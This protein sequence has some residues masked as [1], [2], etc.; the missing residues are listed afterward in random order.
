MFSTSPRNNDKLHLFVISARLIVFATSP[1]I[2]SFRLRPAITTFIVISWRK[3][4]KRR[5]KLFSRRLIYFVISR[6]FI[7]NSLFRGEKTKIIFYFSPTKR[8][9][10]MGRNQLPYIYPIQFILLGWAKK[11][12]N[13]NAFCITEWNRVSVTLWYY[14]AG[15]SKI[16]GGGSIWDKLSCMI[17]LYKKNNI[18]R[19]E[20]YAN[21]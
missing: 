10:E 17:I 12:F 4:D 15:E 21:I 9:N 18:E 13:E 16:L 19:V 1:E 20:V 14:R 11:K 5:D 3:D 6:S 2:S 7:V 8:N